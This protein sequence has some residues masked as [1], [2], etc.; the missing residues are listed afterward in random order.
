MA[1]NDKIENPFTGHFAITDLYCNSEEYSWIL[2]RVNGQEDVVWEF[3][4]TQELTFRSGNVVYGGK[5]IEHLKG[6]EDIVTEYAY[7][8]REKCLYIDRTQYA[9]AGF[10]RICIN[11]RLRVEP[12]DE[13]TYW[14]YGLEG[15]ENEPEDYRLRMKVKKI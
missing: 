1:S 9:D 3:V 10:F 11:N 5:L 6:H 14:L 12:I 2:F 4:Q 8:P 7:Y 13:T 15:I